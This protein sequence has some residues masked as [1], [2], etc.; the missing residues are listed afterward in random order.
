MSWAALFAREE[1]F[2]ADSPL[3]TE[4]FGLS[5]LRAT[6]PF[7][8]E[9]EAARA[10]LVDTVRAA[11]ADIV[12]LRY[13]ARH[14]DWYA[15]LLDCGRDLI[16]ADSLLYWRLDLNDSRRRWRA[17]GDRALRIESDAVA[18][19]VESLVDAGFAGYPSHY[20]ANPLLP[21]E[22]VRAGYRQWALRVARDGE[23]FVLRHTDEG[24]VGFAVQESEGATTEVVLAAVRP[25]LQGGGLY[26]HLLVAC[27][28]RARSAGSA[29]LV[30]S[31]QVHNTAGQRAWTRLGFEPV[32]AVVTVHAVRRGLL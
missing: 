26:R 16:H 29:E 13:P 25:D 31:T 3:D 30:S 4:R 15:G 2:A 8:A 14:V 10:W 20:R 5:F 23:G 24:V 18:A 32:D 1:P 21:A 17:P 27:A 12:V 7:A 22:A 9:V 28:E 11:T 19:D 6:V